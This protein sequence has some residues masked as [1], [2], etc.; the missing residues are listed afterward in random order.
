[1]KHEWLNN[2]LNFCFASTCGCSCNLFRLS[3]NEEVARTTESNK[4]RKIRLFNY[5]YFI[6]SILYFLYMQ[7]NTVQQGQSYL[8]GRKCVVNPTKKH[9]KSKYLAGVQQG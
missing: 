1:M 7:L 6:H 8:K 3:Q 5:S 2:E 9:I 4:K